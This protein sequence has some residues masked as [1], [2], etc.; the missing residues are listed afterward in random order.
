[1]NE[2]PTP[3]RNNNNQQAQPP[4][5]QQPPGSPVNR[6]ASP[7]RSAFHSPTQSQPNQPNKQILLQQLEALHDINQRI[8]EIMVDVAK[9]ASLED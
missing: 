6:I 7:P 3:F 9:I 2:Q 1:M 5:V 8:Q 4:Q